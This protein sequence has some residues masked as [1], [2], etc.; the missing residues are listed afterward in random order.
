MKSPT[1]AASDLASPVVAGGEGT[2]G[3][4]ACGADTCRHRRE[5][6]AQSEGGFDVEHAGSY[7]ELR[8]IW[9][10]SSRNRRSASG[11]RMGS[12]RRDSRKALPKLRKEPKARFTAFLPRQ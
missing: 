6:G 2:A 12:R 7:P 10:G 5:L 4:D 8:R 1:T 9:M 11:V 3:A